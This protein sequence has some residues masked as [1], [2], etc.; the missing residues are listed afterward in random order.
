MTEFAYNNTLHSATEVTPSLPIMASIPT[1]LVNSATED[2][3]CLLE[4][5]R[6]DLMLELKRS[7]ETAAKY[8]NIHCS[9]T[10]MIKVGNKV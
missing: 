6:E 3:V 10:P 8:A 4:Y 1:E 5:V 7:Q 2:R 9:E